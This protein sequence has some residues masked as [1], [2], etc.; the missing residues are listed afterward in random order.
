MKKP[1]NLKF[2]DIKIYGSTEWLANNSKKYRS[3]FDEQEASYI[4]CEFSFYNKKFDEDDWEL[5]LQLKCFD[6]D[7]NQICDLNCDRT[8]DKRD[9][10]VFVREGWGVKT[11]GTYW[12]G[13]AYRWEVWVE[14]E[15]LGTKPFYIEK[16][17]VVKNGL[18]PY[19]NVEFVKLYEGPDANIK[20]EDRKYYKVFNALTTRYIWIEFI[21]QNLVR[22]SED[23]ACELTFN[24]RT[25]TGYTK[26]SVT[27]LIFV[28][29][30]DEKVTTTIGWGSDLLGTWGRGKYFAEVVFMDELVASIPFE[31][32][33]DYEEGDE[34]DFLAFSQ[35]GFIIEDDDDTGTEDKPTKPIK[36]NQ[37]QTYEEVMQEMDQL[38]GLETIKTKIKEYSKYLKFISLRREKGFADDEKINL[39]AVF[40]GNP[41]TGKTTVARMLGKIYKE[42]GLLK[43]GHVH[44]VDR[45][46]LVAEFIGQTA[47]KT[48]EAIKKAKDGIL[49]IDEA[50]SLARKD[51]DSKD[52]GKEAIEMLLKELSDS[53]DIAIIVA[54]YPKE[55]DTFL[56]SN[57]GLKSR[58]NMVYDF[59]DYLPQELI[60][61]ADFA[62][63][64]RGIKLSK[65]ARS[66]LYK[67]LV[68]NYRQRDKFFGNAR[69]VNSLMD[70]FK[71]NLGLRIM[72]V[73]NPDKL[74]KDKLSTIDKEDVEKAF[75]AKK[76]MSPDI[77]ID[78][79]LLK[80]SLTKLRSMMGL[81]EV[82]SEIEELVKLVRFYKETG[83]NIRETFSL[84]SVFLGNPGTGKTTV[85]RILAQIYKAL[86]ILER[87]HLVECDRQSMVGGYIGQTAIK[88]AELIDKAMDGVLFIDEAYSLTESGSSDYGREAI[89]T[90]LKRMED[91]RGKFIVIAAG[92]TQNME[93][94]MESNPGLKSRF[95]RVFTFADFD[96]EA[97]YQ[98]ALNQLKDNQIKPDEEAS[99][100]LKKYIEFMHKHKDKYF[101]NGRAV[102]KVIEDAIRNQHL[103]LSEVPKTKRTPKMVQTLTIEDLAE[104]KLDNK[105]S[106]R[107]GIG[108]KM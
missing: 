69:L 53:S 82:K 57:P 79:E 87:G 103:R 44:E 5:K 90:L 24:F 108:F 48:K 100:H 49:F 8:V 60:E 26:G 88:T 104:F 56:E 50:Y 68:E 30:D 36:S 59:P 41:G 99:E 23:W 91:Y 33:D 102:R 17:G 80:E 85:A 51:D 67:Q 70:E 1:E 106:Q 34:E 29:P 71:M 83:K 76:G 13:G 28:K 45:G 81:E 58:F 15:L 16:Q 18:N 107:A 54:G 35:T 62:A 12:K 40:K 86:G 20:L 66:T 73:D 9:P 97:L 65:E 101:G 47:P 89:E 32:G 22:K 46:D 27:K 7:N 3:V 2:R 94:F 55:M 19:F 61:I 39:H 52:F 84:H 98:I 105:P 64:N 72:K 4:Y 10:V 31:V 38:I 37:P 25:I 78:E 74:T 75:M 96:A 77:P 21:A 93:K 6:K 92:Y 42:L 43:K 63:S 95:D 11:P 14:D